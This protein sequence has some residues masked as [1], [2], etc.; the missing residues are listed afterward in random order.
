MPPPPNVDGPEPA[1]DCAEGEQCRQ[2]EWAAFVMR[3]VLRA[4]PVWM[5]AVLQ[6]SHMD[7]GWLGWRQMFQS[8]HGNARWRKQ[9][10]GWD[11]HVSIL[12][13]GVGQGKAGSLGSPPIGEGNYKRQ[14]LN[15][16]YS[17]CRPP[18]LEIFL[19]R[20]DVSHGGH[21]IIYLGDA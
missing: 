8:G 17:D 5:F 13:T 6:P 2:L 20:D 9:G 11:S 19:S 3:E 12:F 15:C 4:S 21:P 7:V 14:S 16:K 1:R 18:T 10:D